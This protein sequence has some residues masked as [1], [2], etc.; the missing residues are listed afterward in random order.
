METETSS[1]ELGLKHL[2]FVRIAAIHVLV[3]FTSLYDY[4]KQNSGPLKSAVGKVEGAVTAVVTPVYNKFKDVPDTLLVFLDHKVGEVSVKFDKHAPPMAKQ[5]VTQASVLM[6][7][8]TEKAQGFV[9]EARTGGPKAAFN[10]AATEYKCFLVTNSVKAWAKLN[11]YK[12][13]HAVGGKALPVAAHFSGMY[14]DLVTD[15]TQ[16]GY[17]VVGYFPLV[18]VDDIVKAYEKE[19]AA[20]KKEDAT[21]TTTDGNKSSSDSDSD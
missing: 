3:S 20:G 16:M 19:D 21:T 6:S 7:K 8:A 13:I 17:P 9:K 10:Y 2:G 4:A 14:N 1:K 15:M 11:Q 18:P 5:V 12:P